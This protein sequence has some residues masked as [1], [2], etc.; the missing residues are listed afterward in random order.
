MRMGLRGFRL[1]VAAHARLMADLGEERAAAAEAYTKACRETGHQ[2]LADNGVPLTPQQKIALL[3]RL[4]TSDEIAR[5]KRTE[6]AGTLSTR[7]SDLLRAAHYPPIAALVSLSSIDTLL[8]VFG[9]N[10]AALVSPITGR[11]HAHYRVAGTSLVCPPVPRPI[12]ALAI[13]RFRAPAPMPPCSPS[14]PSTSCSLR[15][16]STVAPSLGCT[17]R[18]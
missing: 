17:M 14:P 9:T 10:L 1:E 13:C 7:R 12:R 11:L 6:K 4:L 16:V 8:T 3:E 5:W 2:D 18:S 15:K